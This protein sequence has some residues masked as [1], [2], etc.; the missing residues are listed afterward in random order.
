M[1]LGTRAGSVDPQ[2]VAE[3][4]S[5]KSSGSVSQIHGNGISIE[6]VQARGTIPRSTAAEASIYESPK[7]T[8]TRWAKTSV[9]ISEV[10]LYGK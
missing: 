7:G 5:E 2:Q 3:Q 4:H 10:I 6:C 9:H 1:K 8:A